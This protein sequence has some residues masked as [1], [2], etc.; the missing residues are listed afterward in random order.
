MH[1]VLRENRSC[2]WDR[3]SQAREIGENLRGRLSTGKGC[4]LPNVIKGN[5]AWA[6][7]NFL[8]RHFSEDRPARG[9]CGRGLVEGWMRKL[10]LS[11]Y[12][13][14]IHLALKWKREVLAW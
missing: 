13:F 3:R 9:G 6:W 5:E 11:L 12:Q 8:E 10:R 2:S 7:E 4:P 14:W 1:R